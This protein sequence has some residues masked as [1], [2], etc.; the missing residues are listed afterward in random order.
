MVVMALF[1]ILALVPTHTDAWRMVETSKS[2]LFPEGQHV[3]VNV[4]GIFNM[5]LDTRGSHNGIK[6]D[7]SVMAG[8]V[9][10]NMD[11]KRDANGQLQG[12]IKV[13][14]GGI[15]MYDNQEPAPAS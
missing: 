12:P 15:T 8:L 11:R 3:G 7:Q 10:I 6:M 1:I 2:S 13:K 14:V 9:K 4:P 5:K